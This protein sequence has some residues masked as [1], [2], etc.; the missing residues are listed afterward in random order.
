[1]KWLDVALAAA[2]C[3][4]GVTEV[5][6]VSVAEDVVEGPVAL[7]VA[8]VALATVPLAWRRRAPLLAA[9]LVLVAFG[10]RA[11]AGPPLEIYPVTL[12]VVVAVYS[13]AAYARLREALAAAGLTV[14]AV[15]VAADRGSGTD[16]SPDPLPVFVLLAVVWLIGR[17]TRVHHARAGEAERR[18]EAREQQA[19]AAVGAERARLAR[20]LHDTV[21][22]SLASIVMQ[23]GGAQDV[24]DADPARARASLASIEGAARQGLAEMRA[25]L[26]LLGDGADDAAPRA[27]APG[28]DALDDLIA[29]ARVAGL[30]VHAEVGGDRRP[31]PPAVELSAYRVVQEALTNAMR[32]A[33]RCRATV[34]VRFD[35]DTLD[36]EVVDDG[37][38]PGEANGAAGVGR[39]LVG[40]RERVAVLGGRLETG[41][42]RDGSGFRVH[43]SLPLRS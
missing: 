16:A 13:V 17:V 28:L 32:H 15:L 39:G 40:I 29:G 30:D 43:A 14:V 18:A 3:A 19:A 38:G 37:R 12:A 6:G 42:G 33:G 8:A 7:N 22:H 11:L 27:P 4:A 35:A 23:A 31:L 24:L 36:V 5:L 9:V 10:G 1:V 34:R 25:L 21:S 26:G 2:L 41:P 20:E